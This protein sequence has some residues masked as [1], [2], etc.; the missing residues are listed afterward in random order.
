MQLL[1][2]MSGDVKPQNK[3]LQQTKADIKQRAQRI[4]ISNAATHILDV[5]LPKHKLKGF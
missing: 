2:H 5:H 4:V 3:F 1:F